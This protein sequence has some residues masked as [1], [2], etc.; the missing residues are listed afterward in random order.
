MLNELMD[1]EGVTK[2]APKIIPKRPSL[3]SVPRQSKIDFLE[4]SKEEI[5]EIV[6]AP[7]IIEEKIEIKEKKEI[8]LGEKILLRQK[9]EE[10]EK[11]RKSE[12]YQKLHKNK[13]MNLHQFLS[14]VQNYEQ[15][16][17]YNLELRKYKQLQKEAESFQDK[18]KLSYNT[19]KICNTITHEP[20][21]K[22]TN[23]VLE[24][25]EKELKNLTTF[26]S[27]PR[28]VRER[29]TNE[30]KN[31][32]K[33]NNTKTN[34]Y[35]NLKKFREKYYSAENT[36]YNNT[37]DY[38]NSLQTYDSNYNKKNKNKKNKLKKITKQQSDKFF[39]KQE[40]WLKNKKVSNQYFEKFYQIQNDTYSNIT[41]KPYVSQASLEILDIKNRL[42][43]NN[44]DFYKYRI[45]NS[46]SQYNNLLLNKGRTIWD[47]LY[48]EAFQEKKCCEDS[49]I[50]YNN[51]KKK[52]KF[53]N[54]SSKFFNIYNQKDKNKIRNK[55]N[56]NK[57]IEIKPNNN[58]KK[59]K[60]KKMNKSFDDK[61]N[62]NNINIKSS[63]GN[64]AKNNNNKKRNI[65]ESHDDI[66]E[67][68][69]YKMKN[70]KEKYHWRNSLLNIKPL[71]SKPNDF[72]Y[73]LNIMQCG[74][75]NDN[76]VNKVTINDDTKCKSVIN[77]VNLY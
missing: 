58:N 50:K 30:N 7:P 61:N 24:K 1:F 74:A 49:F 55:R 76:Y 67:Y 29:Y 59:I 37:D 64:I 77:L 12:L 28:E 51:I 31:I 25:H 44:D 5:E 9:K 23:E 2:E 22:R 19:I 13:K 10:N 47:K 75:W 57:S 65:F 52:N 11:K 69:Y 33:L 45:P 38:F 56:L 70:E 20:L 43:T 42:N 41:F 73:H 48:E 34:K 16:K 71:Y 72:T 15:K 3:K 40:K 66:N 27:M 68:N 46:F 14:R 60:T 8:T 17:K 21:Y 36:R 6:E 18:P 62:N 39:E 63:R 54:V 35:E 53:R 4:T 32:P 26:Y